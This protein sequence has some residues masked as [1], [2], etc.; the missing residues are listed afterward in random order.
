MHIALGI[1]FYLSAVL[2]TAK[3]CGA[4]SLQ[5]ETNL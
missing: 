1:Y 3:F 2:V 5:P 4:G